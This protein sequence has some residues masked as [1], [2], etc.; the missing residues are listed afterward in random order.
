[1]RST[2]YQDL[3]VQGDC[4]RPH[5]ILSY[6]IF[7]QTLWRP[8]GFHQIISKSLTSNAGVLCHIVLVCFIVSLHTYLLLSLKM[9]RETKW[10]TLLWACMT[11]EEK[12]VRWAK[13]TCMY[14]HDPWVLSVLV[15]SSS[16]L[17]PSQQRCQ[18][19][20]LWRLV[21]PEEQVEDI[22]YSRSNLCCIRY[23]RECSFPNYRTLESH[24][25]TTS[26]WLLAFTMKRNASLTD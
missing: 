6:G 10:L 23:C 9:W 19:G 5:A 24:H 21:W 12:N 3:D 17:L 18:Y 20:S 2:P 14:V 25:I 1:M 8:S 26:R 13:H 11:D 4:E 7:N 16:E 22:T 15:Q